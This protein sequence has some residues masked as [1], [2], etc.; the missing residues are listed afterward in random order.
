ML[1]PVFYQEM[2]LGSRRSKLHVFR[3]VYA[4][5]LVL[6]LFVFVLGFG[7][8]LLITSGMRRHAPITEF[9]NFSRSY[10]EFMTGQHFILL[11]LVTPT[12]TA[13]AITDEK[14]RGTLQ[15]LLTADLQ[16]GEIVL[17]KMMRIHIEHAASR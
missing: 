12:V 17:G 16:P 7:F 15:Y 4:G 10:V 9:A 2:L 3:W 5:L 13:G 6:E 8:N 11:M 14:S 1:G